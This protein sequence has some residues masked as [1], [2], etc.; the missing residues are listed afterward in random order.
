MKALDARRI[1][2]ATTAALVFR[3]RRWVG[4]SFAP[5][6]FIL[7]FFVIFAAFGFYPLLYTFRLS[8]TYWHG[9]GSP[10]FIGL[11]NYSFL[12]TD[13]LFWQSIGNSAF[14]WL[15]IVPVQTI[16]SVLIAVILSARTLRFRWL[17]RTAFLTPYV[18]PLV[19]VAQIWLIFFDGTDG[20]IN[21]ILQVAHLPTVGWLTDPTWAK[22]TM[23]LMVLWKNCGFS[24]LIMLAALQSIPEALYEAAALD[25]AGAVVQF[26]RITVPMLRRTISFFVIIATL[27]V[28]QM[29]AEPYVLTQGGP[30]NSTTTAGYHLLDYINNADFGTGAANSFLLMLLVIAIALLLPW[31]L[32]MGE[33]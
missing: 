25:G 4:G 14:L 33:E 26:W 18:V 17:F 29:F 11:A 16:F 27:G 8:L 23:A 32:R 2:P 31:L 13:S 3:A 21:T 30:Y 5:Y 15:L 12:L 22:P 9:S 28:L 7:P 24:I 1:P 10:R 6:T 19:A 20:A